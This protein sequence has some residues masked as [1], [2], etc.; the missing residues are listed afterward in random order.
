MSDVACMRLA[1]PSLLPTATHLFAWLF[2]WTKLMNYL[3][4]EFIKYLWIL[5]QH[6]AGS[7]EQEKVGLQLHGLT[8]QWWK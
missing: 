6:W 5:C 4:Y 3:F 8:S 7:G 1:N 2:L